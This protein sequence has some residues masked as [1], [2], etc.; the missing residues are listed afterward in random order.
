VHALQDQVSAVPLSAYGKPY[1]PAPGTVDPAID[2]KAAPRDQVNAMDGA[3]Y[4]KLFA[5]LLKTNPPSAEDAPMVA[6][7]V[8]IGIVPGQ[9]FDASKLEPPVAKGIAAAPKHGQEK[10]ANLKEAIVTGDA[11]VEHGWMFFGKT[12]LYGTGYRNRALITWYGL[13]ANRPQDAVYPTSEGPDIVKKYSGSNKYVAHFKKGEMPP[14][15]AFWSI[16]M[17]DKDYFFVPNPI[18][19]YTVSSRNKFKT[20]ADGSVDLYIQNQSPGPDKETNWLPAPTGKFVLMMRMYWPD[21][22][23]P[24][25]INGTWKPPAAQKVAAENVGKR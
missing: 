9:D 1:T 22:K 4:F 14:A 8:K 11:K 25:I 2:M 6:K 10:I 24:S 3:T 7:L 18:N 13:G 17:Y 23:S 21:E 20:N 16:T 15:N 12:G 5:E 19:R